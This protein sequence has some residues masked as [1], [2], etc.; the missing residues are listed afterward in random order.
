MGNSMP[1]L[2]LR[3]SG[4]NKWV[5]CPGSAAAESG[6]EEGRIAAADEGTIAHWIAA[7]ILKGEDIPE[8]GTEWEVDDGKVMPVLFD[9]DLPVITFTD[10][11]L[12]HVLKYTDYFSEEMYSGDVYVEEYVTIAAP[13]QPEGGTPDLFYI[14]VRTN[15]L[16]IHDLKYGFSP[17]DAAENYQLMLYAYGV[18]KSFYAC[19]FDTY[20]LVIHQPRLN[21]IDEKTYSR[22]E[23]EVQWVAIFNAAALTSKEIA[24][25]I[26]G[27]HCTRYY[28]R[29]RATCHAFQDYVLEDLPEIKEE[30]DNADIGKKLSKIDQIRNWCDAIE[31][32]AYT[33]AVE[34][35]QRIPGF[36]VVAG[37]RGSRTWG[38]EEEAEQVMKSMRLKADVMYSRKLISPTQTEKLFKGGSIGKRKWSKLVELI[39]QPEGKPKL[40][41]DSSDRPEIEV[42]TDLD[43]L[44]DLL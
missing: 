42:I 5:R 30:I 25:V 2:P 33:L 16:E 7:K 13:G 20:R 9:S 27:G 21:R 6:I 12:E 10:E 4:A 39:T 32:E 22:A 17:V 35:G 29:A 41:P 23:M 26:P 28:C 37:K 3:P 1:P 18:T 24:P 19:K 34:K 44:E 11:M 36:K 38:S 8:T 14:D 31:S 40:V 43:L 15:T